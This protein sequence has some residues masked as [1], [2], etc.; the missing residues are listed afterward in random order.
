MCTALIHIF[1]AHAAAVERQGETAMVSC[2]RDNQ[3]LARP[4]AIHS[5]VQVSRMV[6]C[7][8]KSGLGARVFAVDTSVMS[9]QN[10]NGISLTLV[11]MLV[12]ICN[13]SPV[14]RKKP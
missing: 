9:F 10:L 4:S 1:T 2:P 13:S 8:G 7:V 3:V 5:L 14:L 6:L 12:G 11:G